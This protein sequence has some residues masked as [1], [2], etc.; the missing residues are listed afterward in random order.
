MCSKYLMGLCA[1]MPT[2]SDEIFWLD[3]LDK[4]E[5]GHV[6]PVIGP[7]LIEVELDNVVAPLE[8][9]VARRL[10]VEL[11]MKE[12]EAPLSRAL[13]FDVVACAHRNNR[14][15]DYH[16][17]VNRLLKGIGYPPV[18]PALSRLAR[19]TDFKLYVNLGF[20]NLLQRAL[21]EERVLTNSDVC[22]LAFS[23]K[24]VPLIDLP[25]PLTNLEEPLIYALFGKSGTSHDF[26]IS[27]DDLLDWVACLQ[28]KDKQ[29]PLLFDAFKQ[30]T[31]LFIGCD[32]PDWV[33]RF[34]ILSTRDDSISI[35]SK[36]ETE[37][38]IG[39]NARDHAHLVT[40]LN[41]FSPKTCV[42]NMEPQKFVDKLEKLWQQ[43]Q[44]NRSSDTCPALYDIKPGG[45]FLSYASGD[46]EAVRALH[47]LLDKSKIDN[48]FDDDRIR[49][50]NYTEVIYRNI[51]A[52]GVFI[53]VLSATVVDRMTKWY[54]EIRENPEKEK[55]KPV[56]LKEWD[57]AI[58][59]QKGKPGSVIIIPV[60]IDELKCTDE[61]IIK[62]VRAELLKNTCRHA[63]YGQADTDLIGDLHN[64][65]REARRQRQYA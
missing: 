59:R 54:E 61:E 31:L 20:D 9:H 13:L 1:D 22:H 16:I 52:C 51:D 30:H 48:W 6:I 64:A 8:D 49:Y 60:L 41:R 62:V 44:I 25:K 36:Y 4:I 2:N 33:L 58:E 27:D 45:I 29:P 46:K 55:E 28:N 40:F 35:N 32:L 26:V 3:L 19:I 42:L 18:P 17:K 38:L 24:Q 53:P 34:F 15:V 23:P 65:V 21:C 47:E 57:Q 43:R 10:A 39:P 63:P 11:E 7:N 56:F 37:T 12:I 14:D 50:G 5:G